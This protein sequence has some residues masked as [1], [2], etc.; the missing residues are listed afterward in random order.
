MLTVISRNL[1][2]SK[3]F[4]WFGSDAVDSKNLASYVK[5]EKVTHV[6]HHVVSWASHTGKGLLF[7]NDKSTDKAAPQGVIQLVRSDILHGLNAVT[8][9][10]Q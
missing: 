7:Y 8:D 2:Y 10:Q 4:F 1:V 3:K 5:S 6:A 9:H